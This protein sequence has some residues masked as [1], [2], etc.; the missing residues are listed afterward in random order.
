MDGGVNDNFSYP[1]D[2]PVDFLS[3]ECDVHPVPVR[4]VVFAGAAPELGAGD[5]RGD[6]DG[7]PVVGSRGLGAGGF[8]SVIVRFVLGTTA[9]SIR[10]PFGG[11]NAATPEP[12]VLPG[13]AAHTNTVRVTIGRLRRQ[14]GEPQVIQTT[15]DMGYRIASTESG[16]GSRSR[17]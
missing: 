17:A 9:M 15:P 13:S 11:E 1:V 4:T 12:R 5:A 16:S 7:D 2:A 10:S 3:G 8:A 6:S 14:L